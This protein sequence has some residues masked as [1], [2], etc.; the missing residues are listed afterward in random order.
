MVIQLDTL[1]GEAIKEQVRFLTG[2]ASL[3]RFNSCVT[4]T[5]TI[6]QWTSPPSSPT[7][8]GRLCR[9]R[10]W[11][12]LRIFP[13]PRGGGLTRPWLTRT[14]IP[15][16]GSVLGVRPHRAPHPTFLHATWRSSVVRSRGAHFVSMPRRMRRRVAGVEVPRFSMKG[17]TAPYQ[18]DTTPFETQLAGRL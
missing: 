7:I 13:W 4:S 14:R 15:S 3:I 18:V 17:Y 10:V 2:E 16:N 9:H 11:R 6:R 12:V 5:L 8:W 1:W